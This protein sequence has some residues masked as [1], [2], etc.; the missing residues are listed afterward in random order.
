VARRHGFSITMRDGLAMWAKHSAECGA[1]WLVLPDDEASLIGEIV[2]PLHKWLAENDE[3]PP[4]KPLAPTRIP[5][6]DEND[7]PCEIC[8]AWAKAKYIQD[9]NGRTIGYTCDECGNMIPNIG[10]MRGRGFSGN[11]PHHFHL[12]YVGANAGGGAIGRHV[13]LQELCPSC[14]RKHRQE[15]YPT[16]TAAEL[17]RHM[18]P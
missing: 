5:L 18:A 8:A 3:T 12:A 17:E 10:L 11:R 16:E 7:G 2:E 14:Y 6:I 15:V 1:L 13:I 9:E 4:A